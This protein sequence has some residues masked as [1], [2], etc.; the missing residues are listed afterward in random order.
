MMYAPSVVVN[1][2]GTLNPCGYIV[3][4][5]AFVLVI[6]GASVMGAGLNKAATTCSNIQ[7]KYNYNSGGWEVNTPEYQDC[8]D[9]AARMLWW[10]IVLLIAGAI[11]SC[12]ACCACGGV[13][14][15]RK[16]DTVVSTNSVYMAGV[17]P[18]MVQQQ[19]Y[20]NQQQQHQYASQG[21]PGQQQQQ[22]QQGTY[23]PPQP[24]AQPQWQTAPQ[25]YAAPNT[26]QGNGYAQV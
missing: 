21:Y 2:R 13:S 5:M 14:C 3:I 8:I 16:Y 17:V 19:Q 7:D 22:Q 26:T 11:D 9:S 4:V 24:Q 23:V 20:N 1:Q 25:G 10:G 12:V 15:F 18:P 6:V